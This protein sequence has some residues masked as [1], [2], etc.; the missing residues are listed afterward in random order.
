M[1]YA[2]TAGP[3]DP[4]KVLGWYG[5][6]ITEELQNLRF[7]GFM[8]CWFNKRPVDTCP[9]AMYVCGRKSVEIRMKLLYL[10]LTRSAQPF[11]DIDVGLR[12]HTLHVT[13]LFMLSQ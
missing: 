11:R 3:S 12:V 5:M 13:P 2:T 6:A 10:P 9:V 4:T 1:P 7:I 8:H